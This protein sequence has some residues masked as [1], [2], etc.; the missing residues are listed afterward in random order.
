MR[1]KHIL[2][3]AL[4]MGTLA[5]CADPAVWSA[6]APGHEGGILASRVLIQ[7]Q[8]MPDS[9]RQWSEQALS[10]EIAKL[11][12]TPVR[13]KAATRAAKSEIQ[14]DEV[15]QGESQGSSQGKP[16]K[17]ITPIQVD[18]V[19]TMR[20]ISERM[21]TIDVPL[22]YHP[23]ET[24][25]TTYERKGKTITEIKERPGHHTGGYSYDVPIAK[26]NFALTKP[27]P[28][29]MGGIQTDTVWTALAEVQG[30]TRMG[31]AALS[32]DMARRA[33]KRL[34]QDKVILLPERATLVAAQ[35]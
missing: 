16:Q 27:V 17:D 19:L 6:V 5:G 7:V 22:V 12:V 4:V 20:L 34:G 14:W 33:V 2:S 24:V 11:G 8:N 21:A 31:W 26:A 9:Q 13:A 10:Q 3:A 28:S 32:Q 29:A 18:A 1:T 35:Q 25:V 23:G 15:P 30:S